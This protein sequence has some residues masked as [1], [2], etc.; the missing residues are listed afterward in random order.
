[1]QLGLLVGC[2]AFWGAILGWTVAADPGNPPSYLTDRTFP[3][4]AEDICAETMALVA[5]FGNGAEVETMEERAVLVERQDGEFLAM[6]DELR[7]LPRPDGEEGEW[8]AEWLDDWE[9]H[10]G[11]RQ[12]WAERLHAGEDPPFVET[13]KGGD[14]VSEAI[15]QFAETNEM[16]S[17]ATLGD[18]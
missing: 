4:A 6:I 7:R 17:C 2:L 5:T 18:V 9:T 8:V 11:D 12:D 15:D 14:Q 13:P 1:M 16:P 10:V 3:A